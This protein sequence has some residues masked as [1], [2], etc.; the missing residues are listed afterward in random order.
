LVQHVTLQLERLESDRF[1]ANLP[2]DCPPIT[3]LDEFIQQTDATIEF[4]VRAADGYSG[5]YRTVARIYKAQDLSVV[6]RREQSSG[7]SPGD[8]DDVRLFLSEGG[9][10]VRSQVIQRIRLLLTFSPH[11]HDKSSVVA[12]KAEGG[13]NSNEPDGTQG[14]VQG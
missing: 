2:P 6:D 8:G 13:G 14:R 9:V 12:V 3:H 1:L 7:R 10:A 11:R 5:V 4:A